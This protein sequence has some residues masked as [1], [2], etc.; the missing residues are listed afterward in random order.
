M[1]AL[2]LKANID[3]EKTPGSDGKINLLVEESQLAEAVNL[4][5]KNGYP[6]DQFVSLGDVFNAEGLVSSPL[7]ERARYV[8]A[9]SQSLSETLSKIDG[10]LSARVHVVLSQKDR[11]GREIQ[12]PSASVAIHH[13]EGLHT[14]SLTPKIKDLV[15]SSI[16]DLH[17]NQV[18]VTYFPS[19]IGTV[20][21]HQ[22]TENIQSVLFI[23]LDPDSLTA[24]YVLFG[25]LMLLLLASLAANAFLWMRLRKLETP[26]ESIDDETS[27]SAQSQTEEAKEQLTT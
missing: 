23:D 17:Y 9:L 3:S 20:P 1:L 24:F 6:R 19:A 8:Y 15:A 18:S 4:L 14:G 12:T 25:S 7:Q 11:T 21:D 13:A 26:D 27:D 16:E 22:D 5:G 2:L 10:V